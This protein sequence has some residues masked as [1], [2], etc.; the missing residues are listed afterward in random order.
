MKQLFTLCIFLFLQGCE[1]LNTQTHYSA[2]SVTPDAWSAKGRAGVLVND[3]NQ[4]ISFDISFV[5][6]EFEMALVGALGLGEVN[7]RSTESG[8]FI[9]HAQTSLNLQ[10]WMEQELGWD[11]PLHSLPDIIF[12][13]RLDVQSEWQVE[14]SKFMSY[15]GVS[16]AKIVKLQH[17][18]NP[19]KIKLLLQEVNQLK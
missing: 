5:D 19:I 10:Q 7:I 14:I 9:D 16:V 1:T 4:S 15:Q 8:L 2:P 6:Q 11:F 18:N 17:R 3:N 13:H 12:E